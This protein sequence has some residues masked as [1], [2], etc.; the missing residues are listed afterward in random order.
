MRL[1]I[2]LDEISE[3]MVL[4]LDDQFRLTAT[5]GQGRE[6]H[7]RNFDQVLD[8]TTHQVLRSLAAVLLLGL[9]RTDQETLVPSV[10]PASITHARPAV[11][12]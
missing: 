9:L 1:E 6:I 12:L 4:R 8:E 11:H 5:L 10:P 2:E 7:Y 3:R